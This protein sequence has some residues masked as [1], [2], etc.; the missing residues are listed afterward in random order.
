MSAGTKVIAA[1]L[2]LLMYLPVHAG[3]QGSGGTISGVVRDQTGG[4]LPGATVIVRNTDTSS[5]RTLVSDDRGRYTAPD[6]APGPYEI[7]AS[8][9][10]FSTVVRS[11]IRL[12]IGREAVVDFAMTVGGVEERVTVLGEAPTVETRTGSTGVVI[13]EEQI[14]NL[15]LNGRSFIEL[16]T[17]TPGVQQTDSGGR[18]ATTG[19]GIKM[20][21]NGSRYSDNLFTLDGTNANDQFNQAGSAS[22]NALGVEAIREFQVLTNSF[23]AEFG[24]HTGAVINAVTKSGTNAVHGSGF[25][26]HR[27][28]SLDAKNF[29]DKVK[30]PFERNQFGASLG[31]PLRKDRTFFFANYE[32]L[33]EGLGQ[34]LLFTVPSQSARQGNVNAA[35]KPFLDS[36]PLPNGQLFGTTRGEFS[37]QVTRTTREHYVVGRID[38]QLSAGS[39]MFARYT[40]D[41]APVENPASLMTGTITKTRFQFFT[42]EHTTVKGASFLNRA[43]FGLTRSRMDAYD[44]ILPGVTMPRTTF[45]DIDR[46]ILS[47]SVTGLSAYGGTSTNPKYHIFNNFQYRDTVTYT[48]GHHSLQVG[49]ALE[50]LQYNL[51]SDFSSMG[52]FGFESLDV[53]LAGNPRTFD[54]VLP[55][56]DTLRRMR[57][58]VFGFFVQDDIQLTPHLTLNA[59]VRYE[60]TT[61]V[62]EVDGKTAQLID[63]ASPTADLN[64]TTVLKHL[65]INPSKNKLAPR[66]GFAWDPGGSGKMAVRGGVGVFQ[67]LISVSTPLVQNVEVRVPPFFNR[68]SLI[69]SSAFAINFPEAYTTQ[70]RFLAAQT[71]LEGLQYDVDQ[72]QMVKWNVNVQREVLPRTMLELGYTGSRGMNLLRMINTNGRVATTTSDGRLYVAPNTPLRQP[73][74]G[75]MRY[76]TSDSDSI[77]HGVTV[78]VTRRFSSGL[79]TQVSY[80]FS[81]SIDGGASALGSMEFANDAGGSRYLF[82]KDYG[83]SPFDIRHT[84]VTN[85]NYDLPFGRDASGVSRGVVGGWSIGG[86]LRL[87]GGYPFS[88]SSGVDTAQQIWAPLY[89]DLKAGASNNPVLGN[90]SRYFDPAS[91]ALPPAGY[92][93]N[94]GRDTLIGP[95]VATLDGVLAKSTSLGGGR[96]LQ[97]RLEAFNLLN[98]ANFSLPTADIFNTN[99]TVREDAGRITSTS[100]SAR[101]IQLGVKIVW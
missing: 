75:R 28:D 59:G 99:G 35:I 94:L 48:R 101:Q 18:N 92:I 81:K 90:P 29:F 91:F 66:L 95:G 72:P 39:Q 82:T 33:R 57:Q 6:L 37:R 79:Q 25:E 7:T 86:L 10:G 38:H 71:Q 21:V 80:T 51:R 68:G 13:A 4:A 47:I 40:F 15:P 11:G 34:T 98:R 63:Y 5:S 58:L 67:E 26:F 56:S 46:G 87:R 32:G 84:F 85:V 50:H 54:A 45:T 77:Y 9:D 74:F 42:A 16:A 60:P 17:L 52:A 97:L 73:N 2:S 3:A 93:G 88:A 19:F 22:G 49:G 20:S 36:Y 30:P 14:E 70:A 24:R 62:S 83:L 64:S 23:S 41:D 31:G 12:T 89:P 55:G 8:L 65:F 53:F 76:R 78:G 100:T 27:S 69:R 44:F 96:Q 1:M 43:Q 61:G